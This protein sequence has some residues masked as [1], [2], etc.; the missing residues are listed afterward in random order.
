MRGFFCQ[1]CGGRLF[2]ENSV[3]L[4]CGSSLG[5]LPDFA[6][7]SVISPSGGDAWSAMEPEA[8]GRSYRKC[9][10]N[11]VENV[12]TWMIPA[13][14]TNPFC[15][16]CRLNR[17]IPD[18]RP[19]N[20]RELWRKMESAK[21]R[22]VYGL[23][24]LNLPIFPKSQDASRGMA[25]DFLADPLPRFA[26]GERILTGH[27]NGVITINLAEADDAVREN[28]RLNMREVYRTL[29]GHFRHESGHYYWDLLVR[30]HPAR[31]SVR[32]MFGDERA[33]YNSAVHRYYAQGPPAGWETSF[34]T[35]YAAAH[36]WEDWAETWAHYLHII[37]TLETASAGGLEIR[38]AGKVRA[39]ASP[40]GRGFGEIREDWHA[41][42]FV[43]NSLNRSMGMPDPYPFVLSDDIAGKLAFIHEW[44]QKNPARRNS[45]TP[46]A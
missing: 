31:D 10:H 4:S 25:F 46:V 18:L 44:I 17:T 7:L 26:E 38:T 3:C 39:L 35:P 16:S 11:Q 27:I 2:F 43:I 19:A 8:K 5:F 28:M 40:L 32:A 23:L 45:G 41:L 9:Q 20:H 1:K 29:L 24:R 42:R 21:R 12:C 30:D 22:L 36:P 13:D 14:D 37:D 15:T 6:T 33:D 34:V